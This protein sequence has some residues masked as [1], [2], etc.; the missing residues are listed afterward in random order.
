MKL[1]KRSERNNIIKQEPLDE[2]VKTEIANENCFC[3]KG[4]IKNLM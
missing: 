4:D 1:R 3:A 2:F